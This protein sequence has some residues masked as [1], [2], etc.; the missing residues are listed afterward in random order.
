MPHIRLFCIELCGDL[1][2][3]Q[4]LC[5]EMP[6]LA[7]VLIGQLREMRRFSLMRSLA[8]QFAP[9]M[10]QIVRWRQIFKIIE[11]IIE[12]ISILVIDCVTIRSWTQERCR[13]QMA[14]M[15][16]SSM[17]FPI[18]RHGDTAMASIQHAIKWPLV[19]LMSDISQIAGFIE[20]FIA[21]D[22]YPHFEH[23]LIVLQRMDVNY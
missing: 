14:L 21:W 15:H 6:N 9:R 7:Y 16:K 17:V 11:R 20:S 18:S 5:S 12:G 3:G 4:T 8:L 13:D 2:V 1:F 22:S 19:S 10:A 23:T